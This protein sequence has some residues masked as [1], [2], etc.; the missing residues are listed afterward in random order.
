MVEIKLYYS[1]SVLGH[2]TLIVL[3][4]TDMLA[5]RIH[6]VDR[7]AA[8]SHQGKI[9][10]LLHKTAQITGYAKG[11]ILVDVKSSPR[12]FSQRSDYSSSNPGQPD[13]ARDRHLINNWEVIP[14]AADQ[15]LRWISQL[16][17]DQQQG[18][19]QNYCYIVYSNNVDNC[20]SFALK[21]L[22][23]AG[24]NLPLDYL[25]SWIQLP[26]L[27]RTDVLMS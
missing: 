9:K 22:Q 6:F 5:Y 4:R 15:M 14:S 3:D 16:L 12:E 24:I 1:Q 25:K 18:T 23:Q 7:D 10:W 20:G 13:Y 2:F 8:A 21:C 19:Y 17:R 27:I 11:N 26:S